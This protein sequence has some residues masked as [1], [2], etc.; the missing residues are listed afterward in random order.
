MSRWLHALALAA[1]YCAGVLPLASL[2]AA[3]SAMGWR[4]DGTGKYLAAD[5][6][7]TWARVSAAVQGLRYRAAKSGEEQGGSPLPDGVIREWLVLGPV[8]KPESGGIEKDTLPEEGQF[9]PHEGQT[10][11]SWVWRKVTLDTAYLDFATLIGKP[12]EVVAYACSHLYTPTG[13]VFRVNVTCPGGVRV[14]V[15]GKPSQ[16]FGTRFR[17]NL[18]RGWNR[19]LLKVTPG[20]TDWYV[21]PVLHGW[22]PAEYQDQHIAWQTPLPGVMPAFYGGGQGVGAPVIVRDKL[23][24]LSEPN[25]LVCIN[26]ADGRVLWVRHSSY[27]E[28]ATDEEKTH[29]A[30]PETAVLAAKI[31]VINASFVAGQATP[32]QLQE[33]AQLEK[34]LQKQMKRIA[35]AKYTV[36]AVPDVGFSGFTPATDGQFIYT[37]FG[38]GVS[39][40]Y[41]LD[42]HRRWLRVDRRPAVEHGFSSSPLLVEGK[43]VVFERD[44]LAFDAATGQLAWEIPLVSHE[45]LNPGGFFH[46]SPVATAIGGISVIVLGNDTL[47]RASDG[48]VLYTNSDAGNQSVASPVVERN[49]LFLVA[50]L[51]MELVLHTLP[52]QITEPLQLPVQ[53]LPLDTSAFPK[54]YLPWH[55]CSPLVHD[56]LAYLVNNA[57]VLT[58]VEIPA[59]RV[60]YQKL[61]DLD[62]CQAHNEGAARGIGVSPALAGGHI[63]LLGNNGAALVIEPGRVYRQVAKNKIE[64]VV[65]AGHWSERQERFMANPVFEGRRLYL[66]GEGNLY[67]IGP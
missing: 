5:P 30:Y 40:C 65:M 47:V 45:G 27:F 33:K 34:D 19:L 18:E 20:D 11:G 63:Y 56:G 54:H 2:R 12:G 15:N 44:L 31:E 32:E 3:E 17:L 35:A 10:T 52:D 8:P 38:N 43:F 16:P 29:S 64:H 55:L 57:G 25:D 61:L 21:V 14:W 60:V 39:A 9:T 36:G 66:R 62:V 23:Y 53:Q 46:G 7:T 4:G 37:W 22:A 48:K 67:A 42:G 58:V 49:R 6:P 51:R 24:L 41:D 1:A 50:T 26:K 13:G 59:G 28:A